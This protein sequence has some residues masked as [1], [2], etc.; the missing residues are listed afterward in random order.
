[1]LSNTLSTNSFWYSTFP[2]A[3]RREG[4]ISI[5]SPL[6]FS[7][8]FYL[9]VLEEERE[10]EQNEQNEK[11]GEGEGEQN[12]I[13]STK[14]FSILFQSRLFTSLCH[15]LFQNLTA[16]LDKHRLEKG[17]SQLLHPAGLFTFCEAQHDEYSLYGMHLHRDKWIPVSLDIH[18]YQTKDR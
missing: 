11:E 5:V 12:E 14:I 8:S 3:Q 7:F 2:G 4:I 6:S 10:R 17:R 15:V 9:Y 16:L 1:M 13:F 18:I